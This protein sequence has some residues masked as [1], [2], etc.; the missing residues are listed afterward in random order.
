MTPAEIDVDTWLE[1]A[2]DP[3]LTEL[4]ALLA[5]AF[6]GRSRRLWTGV[7]WGGSEQ[8]IIGYGD[9]VQSRPRGPDVE[10]FVVGLARQKKHLSLYVNAVEDRRYLAQVYADR[11]GRVK[12]GAASLGFGSVADLDRDVLIEMLAEAARL[13]AET[14]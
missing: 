10:W 6:A 8:E 9:L 7:F 5:A 14:S 2:A 1:H 12:V 13:T 3:E 4:D 11:L